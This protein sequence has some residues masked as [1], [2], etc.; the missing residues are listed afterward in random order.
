MAALESG[1]IVMS[2]PCCR[3]KRQSRGRSMTTARLSRAA[4]R[5]AADW[6]DCTSRSAWL[7]A[8]ATRSRE[9]AVTRFTQ[10]AVELAAQFLEE[11]PAGIR[12]AGKSGASSDSRRK[13][14]SPV[15]ANWLVRTPT[16][17]LLR[18]ASSAP[19]G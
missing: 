5:A 12:T 11:S 13:G 10:M 3:G 7:L 8:A 4:G 9:A 18:A 19:R 6:R 2:A 17:S 15:F 16:I 14:V 1:S